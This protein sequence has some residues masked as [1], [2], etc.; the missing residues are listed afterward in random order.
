MSG[1][2]SQSA[3]HGNTTR[4][5]LSLSL[6]SASSLSLVEHCYLC[7]RPHLL[8]SPSGARQTVFSVMSGE[9]LTR[10]RAGNP[11]STT[12]S[13]STGAFETNNAPVQVA[14]PSSAVEGRGK[15]AYDPRDFEDKGE[16]NKMPRLTIMEEILLLGLKDKAVR[17][18]SQVC[19][20]DPRV[21]F[22]SGTTI[23]HT[24]Y[25]GASSL[26][27]LSDA[28]SPWCGIHHDAGSPWP[29]G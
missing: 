29:T 13:S 17:L 4:H 24:P 12:G 10:R 1:I 19:A 23:F 18:P 5:S 15:I 16:A 14:A 7:L 20:H 27:L 2:K 8:Q 3:T 25:E 22:L 9:G 26:N 21:I 28:V 6:V 11:A